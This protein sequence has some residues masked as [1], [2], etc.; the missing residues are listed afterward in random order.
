[1]SGTRN[2]ID[3]GKALAESARRGRLYRLYRRDA[4][5][6]PTKVQDRPRQGALS[7]RGVLQRGMEGF[8]RPSGRLAWSD[9][10]TKVEFRG[11]LGKHPQG[12]VRPGKHAGRNTLKYEQA[13]KECQEGVILDIKR[14][15]PCSLGFVIVWFCPALHA[16]ACHMHVFSVLYSCALRVDAKQP[17]S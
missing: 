13:N 2:F 14:L 8:V 15:I 11:T 12:Q 7:W 5:Q 10:W 9:A 3:S 4:S 1:M 6:A 16:H 17:R